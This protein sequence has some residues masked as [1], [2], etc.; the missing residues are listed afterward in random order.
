MQEALSHIT[1]KG[2][3]KGKLSEEHTKKKKESARNGSWRG[4]KKVLRCWQFKGY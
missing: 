4:I 3:T 2:T 1:G